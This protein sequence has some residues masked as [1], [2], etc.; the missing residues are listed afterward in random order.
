MSEIIR[1]RNCRKKIRLAT[2]KEIKGTGLDSKEPEYI[3]INGVWGCKGMGS[4]FAP[5]CA[6]ISTA[7]TPLVKENA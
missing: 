5:V 1:C 6:E 4:P 2:E 3:H 7:Y